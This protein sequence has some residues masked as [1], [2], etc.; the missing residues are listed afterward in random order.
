[1]IVTKKAMKSN[2]TKKTVTFRCSNVRIGLCLSSVS[3]ASIANTTEPA[4]AITTTVPDAMTD[5]KTDVINVSSVNKL[6]TE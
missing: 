6:N 4:T 1:M 5:E 3:T 2:G